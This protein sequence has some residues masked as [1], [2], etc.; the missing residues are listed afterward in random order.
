MKLTEG[1]KRNCLLLALL[2]ASFFFFTMFRLLITVGLN[3]LVILFDRCKHFGL[4]FRRP[5][6]FLSL[7]WCFASLWLG[8]GS[9]LHWLAMVNYSGS[10]RMASTWNRFHWWRLFLSRGFYFT[11]EIWRIFFGVWGHSQLWSATLL[12]RCYLN[13]T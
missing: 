1:T 9:A 11:V 5:L 10:A 7:N 13:A 6:L 3:R 12:L 8:F 4:P 2:L